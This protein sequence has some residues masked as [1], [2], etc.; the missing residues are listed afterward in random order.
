M[1]H[2]E[3]PIAADS[4]KQ[5]ETMRAHL[6]LVGHALWRTSPTDGHVSYFAAG[7]DGVIHHLW[8]MCDVERFLSKLEGGAA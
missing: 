5:F 4:G 8:A 7:P 1:E 3:H 6:A 2:I